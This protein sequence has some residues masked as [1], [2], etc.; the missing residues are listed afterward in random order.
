MY[1][2]VET[3][4][5]FYNSCEFKDIARLGLAE[6]VGLKEIAL[7]IMSEKTGFG[8]FKIEQI[9][10]T[11]GE[12]LCFCADSKM[13]KEQKEYGWFESCFSVSTNGIVCV[14]FDPDGANKYFKIIE[15]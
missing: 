8:R 6:N 2:I 15:N 5:E 1:R 11:S 9:M 13:T 4:K 12:Q 10:V 14:W 3:T 7:T